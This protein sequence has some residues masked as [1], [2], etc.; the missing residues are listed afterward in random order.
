MGNFSKQ[1]AIITGA[2]SGLGLVIAHKLLNEGVRAGLFDINDSIL[3]NEFAGNVLQREI[4]GLDVTKENEVRDAVYRVVDRFG[5]IDILINCVGITGITNIRSH[6]VSTENLQKVFDVNFMSCFYTSKMVLPYMLAN[7]YGRILHISSIAGK[8]GNAGMLAYSASKAA[9]IGMT[10]V[11]GKEYAESGITVNALAPAVIQTP[12]VDAMPEIQVKYMTDKIPMK[13]CGT[14]E[15][16]A[17]MAAFIVSR[18][19]SFTT[20][21]TFDLSGGRATY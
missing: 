20:G 6:E 13:R 21:F 18:E 15:E 12:L 14:L 11:Q 1:V 10:K 17:N 9:V 5:G 16:V 4:I 8:E 2:A 19:S 3:N 7:N